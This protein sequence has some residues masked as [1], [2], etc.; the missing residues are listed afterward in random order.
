MIFPL[1][2]V[3]F[4]TTPPYGPTLERSP[5]NEP[6][7]VLVVATGVGVGEVV[8][9]ADG[10]AVVVA[11]AVAFA[12]AVA[13]FVAVAVALFA[14]AA[15]LVAAGVGLFV[16]VAAAV[17]VDATGET[18]M[19]VPSEVSLDDNCGG[20]MASTAPKLPTVPPAIK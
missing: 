2:T 17:V 7:T 12:V 18:P 11:A 8:A 3:I 13:F 9:V 5:V 6:E 4:T 19:L 10:E 20:V 1:A 14:G 16:C 15:L